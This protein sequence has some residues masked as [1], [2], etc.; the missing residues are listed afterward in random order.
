MERSL[1][2]NMVVS[3][4][5]KIISLI[6]SYLYVPIV[7]NYLGVEKYGIWSTILT[8]LS[9]IS[10]FDIGIGNGLRNRLTES[11]SKKDDKSKKLVSSAYAFVSVIMIGV[12]IV[13]SFI[14]SIIDWK[15]VFGVLNFSENLTVI[16]LVSVFFMILNF[17]MS[18]CKNVMYA[19]QKAADVSVMDLMTQI[20]NLV[21]VLIVRK[22]IGGNLF[23]IAVIYGSSMAIVNIIG[24]LVLYGKNENVHPAIGLIDFKEGSQL[25]SLGVKFFIIQICAVILFTTDSLI[26][27]YLYGA[28]NV[29]PYSTVSKL[30]SVLIGAFSAFLTPIWCAVTKAKTEKKFEVL[31]ELIKKLHALILL[32]A[33]GVV[34]LIILFRPISKMW[35]GQDLEYTSEL[36]IFGGV[37]CIINIWTNTYGTIANGLEILNEQIGMSIIQAVLNLPLSLFFAKNMGM[38]S[39]GILLGTNVTLLIS[40]IYL[41]F[42]IRNRIRREKREYEDCYNS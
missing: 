33:I 10:Y 34:M 32:F 37:Y 23:I 18:M 2:S 30:F 20:L 12:S 27:S 40:S 11:I 26:I 38:G 14:V 5:C 9:W 3:A 8:I 6:I 28:E 16:I 21:S 4:I 35:L 29:T 36:I 7:L 22:F 31:K 13:F 15:R 17:I 39:A 25:T 41:P 42:C 1:E 19:L 24:S